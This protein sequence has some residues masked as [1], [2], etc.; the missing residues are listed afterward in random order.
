MWQLLKVFRRSLWMC[1]GVEV[2]IVFLIALNDV[3]AQ[4]PESVLDS[5]GVSAFLA[6]VL[7]LCLRMP[8][9]LNRMP[10]PVSVPQRAMLPVLAFGVLWGSGVVTIFAAAV[11]FGFSPTQWCLIVVLIL[12]RMPF[13]LLLF[14]MVYRLFQ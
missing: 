2:V 9:R 4:R 1:I 10:F 13:Y 14:L 3:R 6:L 7:S 11:F 5:L 8:S 12:Q